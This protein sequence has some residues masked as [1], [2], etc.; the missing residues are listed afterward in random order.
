[1]IIPCI[2][3]MQGKVV[4]LVQGKEKA[5]ERSLEET[6]DWM[7]GFPLIHVIDL[8]AA[9]GRGQNLDLVERVLKRFRARVGGGIRTVEDAQRMADLG[10][11]MVIVG[12]AAYDSNGPRTDFLDSISN[13]IGQEKLMVAVD[14]LGGRI[15]VKG[16]MATM[17]L[18]PID[19]IG[20]LEAHCGGFLCTNVDKEGLMGGTDVEFFKSLRSATSKTFTAAGGISTMDEIRE[21]TSNGIETAL[22]MAI[23]TDAIDLNELRRLVQPSP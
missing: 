6:M 10:A 22:G 12:S 9:M 15:A 18:S 11:E 7:D 8:D 21:L 16:W 1:M 5:L 20:D 17:N 14:V 2:D 3:V 19:A 13:E 23:Y 4:Q